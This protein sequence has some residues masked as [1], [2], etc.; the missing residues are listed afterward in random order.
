MDI[1]ALADYGTA[2]REFIC[3]KEQD[4]TSRLVSVHSSE[5]GGESFLSSRGRQGQAPLLL[6]NP[7]TLDI[8]FCAASMLLTR[9]RY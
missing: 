7:T 3:H 4:M 1:E 5:C 8:L 6:F 9:H 2:R